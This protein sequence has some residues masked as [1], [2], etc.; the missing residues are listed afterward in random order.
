MTEKNE[1]NIIEVYILESEKLDGKTEQILSGIAPHYVEKYNKARADSI[2]RQELAAGYLVSKCL[3]ASGDNQILLNEYGK[4][5][6]N[7][8]C[9]DDPPQFSISHSGKYVVMAVSS[10]PVGVDIE[11]A[12]RLTLPVLSRILPEKY[13]EKMVA[14]DLPAIQNS[15]KDPGVEEKMIYA[16]YWTYVE[17]VLKAKGKGFYSDPRKEENLLENWNIESIV[18]DDM[19]VLSCASEKT[20]KIELKNIY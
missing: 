13:I 17:A 12:D 6:L 8:E 2:K 19:Y 9:F 10:A 14:E 16:R 5:Y 18:I 11:E 1:Q 20:F 15:K 4:P 3:G 7:P